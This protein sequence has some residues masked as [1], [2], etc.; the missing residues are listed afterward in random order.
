MILFCVCEL[1]AGC[2]ASPS[3]TSA[4]YAGRIFIIYPLNLKRL[5]FLRPYIRLVTFHEDFSSCLQVA[6]A[7]GNHQQGEVKLSNL[8]GDVQ[9]RKF[10][11]MVFVVAHTQLAGKRE[12][13]EL[14]P[15]IRA[16]R[17]FI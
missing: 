8:I 14:V 11:L 10:I 9:T 2:T 3:D 17:T 12:G 13:L 1:R 5:L 6:G 7:G 16:S 4:L 15:Y